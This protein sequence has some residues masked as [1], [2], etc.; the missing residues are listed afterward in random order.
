M[1]P[2]RRLVSVC[3]PV[4]ALICSGYVAAA[5]NCR[6]REEMS[7]CAVR[8]RYERN[9]GGAL[10]TG[11]GTAFGV[12]LAPYGIHSKRMMLSAA[13]NV[14]DEKGRPYATL[15]IEINEGSRTYWSK[16]RVVSSDEE[17]D[18]CL[19]EAGDD[20]PGI[21]DLDGTDLQP[22][23]PV[24]LAGSPRGVPIGLFDG[25]VIRRFDSGT[26]RSAA[27]LAF[28]HGDSGGPMFNASTKKVVGVAVAGVPKNGD[29]DH[30][31]GLFVPLV[32]ID[33]FLQTNLKMKRVQPLLVAERSVPNPL[34][35]KASSEAT[36]G[37]VDLTLTKQGSAQH[38]DAKP[39]SIA[40]NTT[41][42]QP[43][44]GRR[45]G[46]PNLPCRQEGQISFGAGPVGAATFF[47]T[48]MS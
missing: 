31:I 48:S 2:L 14:L 6:T 5:A 23:S 15:K 16:C 45:P 13:H 44:C 19:V 28:D 43:D 17:L 27:R 32:A 46:G 39:L 33:S 47:G 8:I 30:N 9:E 3:A 18:I 38:A 36:S 37:F 25:E 7:A 35:Q 11:H 10:I 20:L 34:I 24:V 42:R 26:I 22:G 40:A 41:N 1:S 21:A 29:L 12:N 4:L